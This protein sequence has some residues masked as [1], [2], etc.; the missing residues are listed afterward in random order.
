M[1]AL[2]RP[3]L[4]AGW[5][6]RLGRLYSRGVAIGYGAVVVVLA[7]RGHDVGPA[8]VVRLALVTLSL[9][10]GVVALAAARAGV[11]D[12]SSDPLATVARLRGMDA[13]SIGWARAVAAIQVVAQSTAVPALVVA[14]AAVGASG[15]LAAAIEAAPLVPGALAYSIFASAVLGGL[16]R[17]AADLAP[18]H[19][20]AAFAG[21]LLAPEVIR[22]VLP[23]APSIIGGLGWLLDHVVRAGGA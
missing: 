4:R 19:G 16:S 20:G 11:P 6:A 21:L 23:D 10:G 14:G 7:A 3:S 1:A 12:V 5:L 22:A 15:S 8:E 2:A 18:R 13:G 17:W 9:T